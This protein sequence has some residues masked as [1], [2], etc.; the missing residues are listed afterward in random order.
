MSITRKKPVSVREVQTAL[1]RAVQR[2]G[3][4]APEDQVLTTD[5]QTATTDENTVFGN[6]VNDLSLKKYMMVRSTNL[7]NPSMI[8]C[9]NYCNGYFQTYNNAITL[10]GTIDKESR[11]LYGLAEND[12]R[13][14]T[15]NSEAD[16]LYWGAKIALGDAARVTA[17]GIAMSNPS[18]AQVATKLGDFNTKNNSQGVKKTDYSTSQAATTAGMPSAIL[19]VIT[20]WDAAELFYNGLTIE[21]RR[22]K[23]R[24]WGEVF[25]SSEKIKINVIVK[26]AGSDFVLVDA[27][28]TVLESGTEYTSNGLG[29]ETIETHI[30]FGV[31]LE[32]VLDGFV[33]N[34]NPIE[35]TTG[36]TAY[37]V[38]VEMVPV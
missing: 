17:G 2:M 14:P 34:T 5:Q 25:E 8:F 22:A 29:E 28:T 26:K 24:E 1:S 13:V 4:V 7:K 38:V 21:A 35:F 3:V 18:A 36:V 11:V 30:A 37:N 31:T 32:T 6:L 16:L 19:Q 20:V 33:T 12:G 9:R 15:M 10:L 23:C 27:L